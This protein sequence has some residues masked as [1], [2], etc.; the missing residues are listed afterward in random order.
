M[1]SIQWA[2]WLEP[3]GS[4]GVWGLDD[5]HFLPFLFG[6]S[7]LIGH[8]HIRPKS[9]HCSETIEG[10]ASQYLYLDCIQFVNQVKSASLRW[11][12][13]LL[14]DISAVKTWNSVY[15]GLLKMYCAEVLHKLPV[16]QHF[17]TGT[18]IP[19]EAPE[20]IDPQGV[21]TCCSHPLHR[22]IELEAI[23]D[24]SSFILPS[25]TFPE[26]CGIRVPSAMAAAAADK[27]K[28]PRRI[29]FD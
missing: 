12:S 5:Y 8:L 24:P 28:T 22:D 16:M 11:H 18:M 23:E 6:A 26:C 1:R 13:P 2:Y 27:S 14:D 10:Y 20:S 21:E 3:A 17:L 19:Y 25:N 29:P 7:Q 4:H 15:S 9:I